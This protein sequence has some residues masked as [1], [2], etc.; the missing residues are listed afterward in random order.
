MRLNIAATQEFQMISIGL[1]IAAL[2]SLANTPY[3]DTHHAWASR[4][5]RGAY[6]PLT[7]FQFSPLYPEF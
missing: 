6:A 4:I 5:A 7:A 3:F 2:M 1:G